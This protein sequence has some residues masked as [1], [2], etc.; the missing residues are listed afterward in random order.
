[1]NNLQP[2]HTKARIYLPNDDKAGNRQLIESFAAKVRDRV[3]AVAEFSGG[4]QR[5]VLEIIA[6]REVIHQGV[7]PAIEESF[8]GAFVTLEAVCAFS[9][10]RRADAHQLYGSL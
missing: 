1:M 2:T 10:K 6:L 8:P 9:I 4:D 3:N 5:T 7:V